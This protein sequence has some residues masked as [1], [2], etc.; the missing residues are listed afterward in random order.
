MRIISIGMPAF[1]YVELYLGWDDFNRS[2]IRRYNRKDGGRHE[3]GAGFRGGCGFPVHYDDRCDGALG[4]THG[5]R[6]EIRS[7]CETDAGNTA[8]YQFPVSAD[9]E[10][11]SGKG[12][13]INE[14]HRECAGAWLGMYTGGA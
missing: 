7:D 1:A 14:S 11:A 3:C 6:A 4:R 5:D 13:Y 2:N 9:S 10:G 12:V 8:I